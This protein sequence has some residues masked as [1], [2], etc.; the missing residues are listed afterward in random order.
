MRDWIADLAYRVA[1]NPRVR[2]LAYELRNRGVFADL[3][4]HDRMLADSVRVDAYWAAIGKHVSEGDVVIDLGTGSGVLA[5]FAA[6]QGARVHAVEHGP[7]IDAAREVARANGV[8]SIEF[9]QRNSRRLELPEKVDAIVHEQIGDALFDER[10]VANIADLR[11]RLLKPGG[12]IYPS[13]LRLFVEPVQLQDGYR[14]PFAWQQELHGIG[15]GALERF[16]D[17]QGQGYLYRTFRP[18]PFDRF[19]CSPEPVVSVDLEVANDSDLPKR[20]AYERPVEREG[21]LDGFVVYFDA[22]FDDEIGFTSSP[23]SAPTSWGTPFLR[24]SP[25]RVTPGDS[26][27]LELT[28]DDLADPATWRWTWR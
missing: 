23:A 14:A 22:H 11:D 21:L 10:V 18:F 4:Q 15:F 20:I 28:A 6:R 17:T 5:L 13:R 12:R 1:R 25:R 9:H 19:L 16:G 3:Y 26:V 24:V 8:G 2:Q 7:I 27:R